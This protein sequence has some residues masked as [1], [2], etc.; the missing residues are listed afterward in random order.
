MRKF[1]MIVGAHKNKMGFTF[2]FPSQNNTSEFYK[3]TENNTMT[4]ESLHVIFYLYQDPKYS[5]E[6]ALKNVT[7]LKNVLKNVTY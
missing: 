1:C 4:P 6:R 3:L 7:Y 5:K 2:Y